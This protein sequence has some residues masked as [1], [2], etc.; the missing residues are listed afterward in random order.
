M[1]KYRLIETERIHTYGGIN[2]AKRTSTTIQPVCQ[3]L[4]HRFCIQAKENSLHNVL[5]YL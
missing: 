4:W 5:L 2:T 3:R 1:I